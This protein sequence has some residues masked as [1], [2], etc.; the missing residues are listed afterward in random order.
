M[1]DEEV[2]QQITRARTLLVLDQ[3]FIGVLALRLQMVET[4]DIPTAAVDGKN[5]YYN[6]A[7]VKKLSPPQVMTLVAHEVFH[8]VYDHIGRRGDRDP[9]KFN[10][11]GDYV[12]NNTLL[13]SGF[14][15]IEGWLY[16]PAYKGM[17]TDH[18]YSL[19]PEPPPG[20]GKG[21]GKM[22]GV[23]DGEP[24]DEVM[25]GDPE[26]TEID[27]TEWKIATIQAA[28]AAKA[29]GKLP[30]AME[31]FVDQ[32]TATKLDWRAMLRR[33]I[34]ERSRDD[35]SWIHLNRRFQSQG[36]F[37]PG[38]FSENMGEIVIGIDTSGSI[39]QPTLNAFGAEIRDIVGGARP[40]K[41]H[42]VYCDSRINHVDVFEPNDDLKFAM[43]G[44]GGTA[45]Q[46]VFDYVVK[47]DLRPVCLVYLTDLYGQHNF[48]PPDYPVMWVCTTKEQASF[49]ETIPIEI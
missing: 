48:P 13:E 23:G 44:G 20:G 35:Y 28:T 33:F 40:T 37:L 11:A 32:L 12:I 17:S 2:A 27:A 15:E 9:R 8:C 43:H 18:I 42:V 47:N 3:P 38:L 41:T 5:I 31:R 6:P 22:G 46:P 39:D 24:L 26:T 14:E 7:F 1:I 16:N 34:T 45:F 30:G 25:D 49:G 4:P 10:Q 21:K 19:L 36:I 29:M